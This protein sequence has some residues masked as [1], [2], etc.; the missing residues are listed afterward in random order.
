MKS[1]LFT[2]LLAYLGLAQSVDEAMYTDGRIH[3]SGNGSVCGLTPSSSR[4]L[5]AKVIPESSGNLTAL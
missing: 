3:G 2:P 1:T 5:T 4:R